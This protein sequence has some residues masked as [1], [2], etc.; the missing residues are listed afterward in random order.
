MLNND[1]TESLDPVNCIF[2]RDWWLEAL[3]PGEWRTLEVKQGGRTVASMPIVCR[4]QYGARIV[5][6]PPLAF[7]LGPWLAPLDCKA[8]KRTAQENEWLMGLIDQ[9]PAFDYFCQNWHWSMTNVLPF[10]WRGFQSSVRYT[11]VIEE[12]HDFGEVWNNFK[13]SVRTDIRK[14]QKQLE[15]QT[16]LDVRILYRL[17]EQSFARWRKAPAYSL[18]CLARLDK[19]CRANDA[20]R[21]FFAVDASGKVHAALYLVWD[22]LSAHYLISGADSEQRSSGAVSLLLCEAIQ[23]ASQRTRSFD[24]QGCM[25][26]SFEYFKRNFGGTLKPLVQVRGY[27]KRMR[28]IQGLREMFGRAAG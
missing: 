5:N 26:E 17:V 9:L 16:D 6:S 20:G 28:M 24:F 13:G 19:A 27:S 15:I 25:T 18:E 22:D 2:Q 7:T 4:N 10:H 8:S 11:Y 23:F 3:A 21:G 12:L 14:A 1:L